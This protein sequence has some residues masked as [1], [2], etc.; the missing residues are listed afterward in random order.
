MPS[1]QTTT[2]P[3]IGNREAWLQRAVILFRD[4]FEARDWELGD[5]YVSCGWPS[6]GGTSTE[7][8][9]L[10]EC[11]ASR[12][13]TD[14]TNHIFVNPTLDNSAEVLAVLLHELCHVVDDCEHKHGPAFRRIAVSMGLT[15]KMTATV[16]GDDALNMIAAMLDDLGPYP[17]RALNP[18][19]RKK[20][21]TRM[22]K[23]ECGHCGYVART[24]RKWL[25]DVGPLVC[26]C[27]RDDT[28]MV[29]IP[30]DDQDADEAEAS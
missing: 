2:Q 30:P 18:T 17:H 7:R 6:S 4:E 13:A 22:I 26:P 20:Q 15:G 1:D 10:G 12:D 16:P 11:W 8:R 25:E 14:G 21:S 19:P 5:V 9:V 27:N 29:E 3:R 28:M 23:M 24:T